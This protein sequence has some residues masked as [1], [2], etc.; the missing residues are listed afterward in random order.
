MG[1]GLVSEFEPGRKRSDGIVTA[2]GTY[3]VTFPSSGGWRSALF[4]DPGTERQRARQ[5]RRLGREWS[6]RAWLVRLLVDAPTPRIEV[7]MEFGH[8]G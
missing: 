3:T 1:R 7:D 2:D 5:R 8:C 6:T 4:A